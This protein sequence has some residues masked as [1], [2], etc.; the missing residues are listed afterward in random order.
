MINSDLQMGPRPKYSRRQIN[1]EPSPLLAASV[2]YGSIILA[3]WVPT[4]LVTTSM[5][6]VPPMGFLLLVGWRLM[7]PGT[8]PAWIGFPLGAI[9]DLV[10]GQ[11]FGSAILLWSV[12]LLAFEWFE[13]RFPWRGFFQDWLASAIACGSYVVLAVLVSGAVLSLPILAAITPQLLLSMALYPIIAAM[14]AT[15]DRIRLIRIREIR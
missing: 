14:V 7:R 8:L 15:L 13:S 9:D 4:F 10:S 12:T 5:P 6:L 2:L 3:S 1:R 11:P